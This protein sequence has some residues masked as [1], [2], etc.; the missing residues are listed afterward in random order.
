MQKD[1]GKYIWI[2]ATNILKQEKWSMNTNIQI[3]E[4]LSLNAHPSL[5]T[6]F[7]DGWYLCF[8]GGYTNRA[9]S[10]NALY[11]SNI[12]LAEKVRFCESIYLQQQLPTVFKITPL[13]V[14]LESILI[15]RDY[16][17][18]TPTNLMVMDIPMGFSCIADT[19]VTKGIN[20]VWQNSYFRLNETK[21]TAIP[22]AKQIHS[23]IINQAICA[24]LSEN[25]EVVACGL[26]IIERDCVGLYDIVV[27]SQH[28]KKGYGQDICTS[29]LANAAKLGVRKAYLQVVTDNTNAIK[30]Y[31][32]LGF[33]DLYQYWYRV[34]NK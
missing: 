4:E 21:P 9:N 33:K 25:S 12:P 29:L 15:Q 34:E 1:V 28:R 27:S 5:N 26:G 31:T 19:I 14:D 18:V 11:T 13:S 32:K 10:V 3:I 20:K 6:M 30:L 24:T 2:F 22:I 8:A 7:Y 23:N 17:I 16:S